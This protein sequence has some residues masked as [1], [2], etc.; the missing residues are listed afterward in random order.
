MTFYPESFLS[1]SSSAPDTD[2]FARLVDEEPDGRAIHICFGMTRVRRR[3]LKI[4]TGTTT[5]GGATWPIAR[6]IVGPPEA[7][8]LTVGFR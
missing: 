5:P 1:A 4:T 3:R 7:N 2:F 8:S 6:A